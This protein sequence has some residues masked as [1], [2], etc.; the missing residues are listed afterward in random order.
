MPKFSDIA[1][2]YKTL[3]ETAIVRTEKADEVAKAAESLRG[4][5]SKYDEVSVATTVPWF[6]IGM[7]H[8]LEAGF[9]VNSHL[10]NGDSLAAVTRRVP[11]GHPKNGSPPFTWTASAIDA[12]LLKGLQKVGKDAWS[13]ERIAYELERYNGFGYR[14]HHPSVKSPYLWSFTNHYTKGKYV[15]DHQFDPNE[16][17]KQVGAMA[18]LKQLVAEKVVSLTMQDAVPPPSPPPPPVPVPTGLFLADTLPFGLRTEPRVDATR[19]LIVLTDMPVEKLEEVDQLW[20]KVQVIAPD[21]TTHVGFARRDWVKPQTVLSSFAPEDFAQSCLDAARHYGT[22]AH[23]LLALA[24]AETGLANTAVPGA[25]DA[26]GPLALTADEWRAN[27]ASAETG[28]AD[29][30]RFSPA[31]QAAVAARLVVKLTQET[32]DVLPDK[33]LATSEEL[34][35]ARIFGPQSLKGLLDAGAQNKTVQKALAPMATAE[36]DSAFARRPA[37]LT[38][39]IKV[40]EL[41]QS[42]TDKLTAG[43]EIAVA[44]ILKVEPD[45]SLGPAEASGD[46]ADVPWMVKA[47]AELEKGVKEFPTGSNPEIVKYFTDTTLGP[48]P[49]DVAWC[50]AFVSWCIKESEGGHTPSDFSARAADWLKNGE[51]LAGPQYGAVVVT[52]PLAAKSSGHVGFAVSWDATKVTIL[53]GN[54]GDAVSLRDFHIADVRGWRMV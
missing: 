27:N 50:G 24:D 5:K 37:L 38:E 53:G 32:R 34:Y 22:S 42:I 9:D 45:L 12:L 20:W 44:L 36:I 43:F 47:K 29:D 33:R 48:Q 52:K 54:Q 46:N 25:G 16:P 18:I 4:L 7:I 6:V 3:W 39:G 28:F 23:F 35:L 31:G 26:F 15:G 14:D 13:V 41:R 2:E 49:D 40:K 19:T 21:T 51:G 30:G 10:H 11:K 17:S 8:S 1:A